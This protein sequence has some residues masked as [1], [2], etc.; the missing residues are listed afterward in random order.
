[1]PS[2][3]P[4]GTMHRSERDCALSRAR[5]AR[6]RRAPP[7]AAARAS[8]LGRA[9]GDLVALRDVS[10]ELPAGATLAVLGPNGSGKTTLVRMLATL[11]RPTE[12]EVEVPGRRAA[13]AGLAGARADRPPGARAAALPRP[14]RRREPRV[15]RPPAPR[16]GRG[17]TD[18]RAAGR[19]SGWSAAGGRAGAQP[20]GRHGA[21]GRGLPGGAARPELLLLDEPRS[22]LDPEAAAMVEPLIGREAGADPGAGQP[23]RGGGARRER[24]GAG[25]RP[26]AAWWPTRAGLAASRPATP[27]RRTGA[28]P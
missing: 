16:R 14:H 10:F 23:R 4:A 19:Q 25:P 7:A 6:A 18:R 26:A 20:L 9:Y 24:P 12:G 28:E 21:A 27:A 17:G 5:P 15:P 11:L 1:M 13:A 8:S 3:P 2:C 22:H